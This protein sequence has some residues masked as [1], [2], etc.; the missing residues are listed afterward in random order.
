MGCRTV[1]VNKNDVPDQKA[2][3]ALPFSFCAI[4]GRAT[5][6]DV[7]SS[8]AAR[9]MIIKLKNATRNRQ[10]GLKSSGATGCS[11]GYARDCR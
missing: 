3:I 9:F 1:E 7:A 11:S 6:K 2:S 8:A 5:D 4:I 10:S